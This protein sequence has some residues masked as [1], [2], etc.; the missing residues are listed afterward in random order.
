MSFLLE[1]LPANPAVERF[2]DLSFAISERL[3]RLLD[4]RGMTQRDLANLLGQEESEIS[5]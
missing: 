4:Q 5:Q 3:I 1:N 2:I